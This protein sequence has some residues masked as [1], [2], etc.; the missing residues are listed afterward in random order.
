MSSYVSE[1][2]VQVAVEP[3]HPKDLPKLVEVLKQLTIEDPN[4]VVKIDEESGETI[5]AGMGVLHLDV[6]T[7]RI[8]D[9]KVDIVTSEPL[10]NYRE[11][12]KAGCE[13]IMS[14]SPNRHNKLFMKVEPLEP[15]I[16]DMLRSGQISEMKDKKEMSDLSK[17]RRMGY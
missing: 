12:V 1:P 6:A 13:P 11:T 4:L 9:A 5:V 8:Q 3:K 15:A 7:H 2:V 17:E 16:G 10:I 14:K